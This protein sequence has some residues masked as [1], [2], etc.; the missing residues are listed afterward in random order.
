MI[1]N[2]VIISLGHLSK[3]RPEIWITS[4]TGSTAGV[5]TITNVVNNVGGDPDIAVDSG[6]NTMTTDPA[7]GSTEM[8]GSS[9]RWL[10]DPEKQSVAGLVAAGAMTAL[11]G[12]DVRLA[13]RAT[14]L[15][16]QNGEGGS[17]A[18]TGDSHPRQRVWRRPALRSRA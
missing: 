5:V 13:V 8:S 4:A 11:L 10:G 18:S 7:A 2:N 6:G 15:L 12:G 9:S 14:R 1:G 3:P 16:M 17:H